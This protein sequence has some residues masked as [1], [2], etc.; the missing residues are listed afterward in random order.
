MLFADFFYR[1]KVVYLSFLVMF[2][3][4]SADIA[5]LSILVSNFRL[6]SSKQEEEEQTTKGE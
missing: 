4:I 2:Y 1:V 6:P 3:N 5:L